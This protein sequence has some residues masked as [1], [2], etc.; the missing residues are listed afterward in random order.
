LLLFDLLKEITP[1]ILGVFLFKTL[2]SLFFCSLC[3][4]RHND[5]LFLKELG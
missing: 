2:F 3:D 1:D 5:R 4:V